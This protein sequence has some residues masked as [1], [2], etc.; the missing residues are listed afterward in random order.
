[1]P[2]V[3]IKLGKT[4]TVRYKS[5]AVWSLNTAP[6]YISVQHSAFLETLG[7]VVVID[8][9]LLEQNLVLV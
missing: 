8:S 1:M 2:F 4:V 9:K 6:A 3:L 7:F 5:A